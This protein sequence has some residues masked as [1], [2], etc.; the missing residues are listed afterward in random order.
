MLLFYE[1]ITRAEQRLILSYPALDQAAQPLSPSP[2]LSEL[3]RLFQAAALVR[4]PLGN[5]SGVP[6]SDD[7]LS[8]R[9]FRVRAVAQ[10]LEGN[11]AMLTGLLAHPFDPHHR[12]GRARRP[13]RLGH[14]RRTRRAFWGLRR[15][16]P[17][18]C[19]AGRAAPPFWT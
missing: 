3:E 8:P 17:E 19:R 18:R 10:A 11:S 4:A 5:L 1:V 15:D 6:S 7:V 9:E 12:R 16:A 13:G 2:Y 14:T